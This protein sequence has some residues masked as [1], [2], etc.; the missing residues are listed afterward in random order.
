MEDISPYRDYMRQLFAPAPPAAPTEP[1]G[2]AQPSRQQSFTSQ[3]LRQALARSLVD[4]A[5]LLG[6]QDAGPSAAG[7][8]LFNI[9]PASAAESQEPM[10]SEG[11]PANQPDYSAQNAQLHD[12]GFINDQENLQALTVS[13]GNI[14]GAIEYII[15]TRAQ[16]EDLD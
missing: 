7:G 3:M 9:N 10:E 1:A 8:S 12:F 6:Q 4:N 11:R 5:P 2:A 14:E 15:T 13:D 16:M